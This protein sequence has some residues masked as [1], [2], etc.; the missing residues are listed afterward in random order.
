MPEPDIY[1]LDGSQAVGLMEERGVPPGLLNVTGAARFDDVWAE[2]RRLMKL[3][4][5]GDRPRVRVL[6]APGLHDTPFVLGMVLQALGDDPRLE[7]VVKPHPKLTSRGLASLIAHQKGDD[8]GERAGFTVVREGS[9]YEWM[10]QSDIFLATYS[11]TAV[12]ALAFQLPVVLLLPN[13]T[14]DMSLYHGRP[15][16]VLRASGAEELRE[17]VNRLVSDEGFASD[18]VARIA[19]VLEESFG[20]IDSR[21]SRRLA[22]LCARAAVQPGRTK[23]AVETG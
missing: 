3:G 4:G 17:H 19:G 11:S 10:A 8:G 15:A 16:P 1:A 5:D 14:P 20:P 9:I 23:Q 13:H 22:D 7:L 2:A 18:Y 12:E 6:V 21:S